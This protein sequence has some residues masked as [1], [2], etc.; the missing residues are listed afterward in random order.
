MP[1]LGPTRTASFL[2]GLA[3]TGAGIRG[4]LAPRSFAEGFGL[5]QPHSQSRLSILNQKQPAAQPQRKLSSSSE[6]DVNLDFSSTSN[7]NPFIPLVGVRNVSAGLSL[8]LFSLHQNRRFAGVL[9]LC[10]LVSMAGDTIICHS[11][12]T[13]KSVNV[14]LL[15]SLVAGALGGYMVL[16][17]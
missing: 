16:R 11:T 4:I 7:G 12:G 2:L 8:L 5:P 17:E 6:P 9:L 1:F 3:C 10:N 15:A 13:S 14:H